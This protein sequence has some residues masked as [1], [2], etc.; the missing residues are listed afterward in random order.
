MTFKK[1]WFS[2]LLWAFFAL[3]AVVYH[4][5]MMYVLLG[6]TPI[7]DTY[8]Q[9][10]I[11]CL[12]FILAAGIFLLVRRLLTTYAEHHP[13]SGQRS[14]GIVW[15]AFLAILILGAGLFLR[16]Y[17]FESGGEE[18]AYFETAMVTGAPITPIA[19]GAEYFY[20]LL[21]R[22]LF[23]LVGNHFAAGII[24]QI[25]LQTVSA[26]IWY[27]AIRRLCGPVASVLFLA[28]VM[29]FPQSIMEGLT[30]SP[31]MLYIFLYGIGLLM[32]SRFLQRQGEGRKMKWYVWVHTV[33]LGV[34]I[35]LLTYLDVMGFTL[36]LLLPF[37]F[38][39]NEKV[40]SG[41]TRRKPGNVVLQLLV[42]V[43]VFLLTMFGVLVVDGMQSGSDFVKVWDAWRALYASKGMGR[44][45][46]ML[47]PSTVLEKCL[48]TAVSFF[49]L[50][51][52]PAFF[53]RKKEENQ[54]PAFLLLLG[55]VYIQ[56]DWLM[57]RET[58]CEY[59]IFSLVFMLM[60]AGI[61]AMMSRD[62][63]AKQEIEPI[64]LDTMPEKEAVA[65]AAAKV[66]TKTPGK[67]TTV[68]AEVP[69]EEQQE[70]KPV[71][72]I[73]NPLPLPKKHVKKTMDYQKK[74]EVNEME[75]DIEVPD[76][77]DF[78]IV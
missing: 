32:T 49:L 47:M 17:F 25:I 63:V 72:Y 74:V 39:V 22:G 70:K 78:D 10:G 41:E 67:N 35:G 24:L 34:S 6:I 14:A 59:M 30:Y 19:H 16:V 11:V 3:A 7:T 8:A 43:L 76:D 33:L 9:V 55:A 54:M 5:G 71:K 20:V 65:V 12:S 38:F 58:D 64:E 42:L 15:E 77:D 53:S 66:E 60:G 37:A 75:F 51:G 1:N 21:L 2:Y 26:I 69:M 4:I 62:T 46:R 36:F 52:I 50:L 18:A 56:S 29:L 28:G 45:V 48:M 13:K 73:E 23:W 31:K 68:A 44:F 40:D 61:Q 27:F 57:V